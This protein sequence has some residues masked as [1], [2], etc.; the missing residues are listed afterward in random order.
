MLM[1]A[2][3]RSGNAH[4]ADLADRIKAGR[5]MSQSLEGASA[6]LL[7]DNAGSGLA[8]ATDPTGGADLRLA[9]EL[10][11]V[12]L[13]SHIIDPM[14]TTFQGM[15]WELLW[16]ALQSPTW[17]KAVWDRAQA[18]ELQRF[19]VPNAIHLPMAAPNR[20]YDVTPPDPAKCKLVVSFVG[21]QNTTYFSSN[22]SVPSSS[23]LSGVLA[24]AV[25]AD[26]K[27]VTFFDAYHNLFGIGQAVQPDDTVAIVARKS[28]QYFHNK[29]F[30]N[31]YQCL[32]QRD[33]FVIFLARQL[34]DG[35]QLIGNGWKEAY[36]IPSSSPI[37]SF[38]QYLQQFRESAI[39]LN[40]VNGN[41]ETGVNMR[42]FEITAAGGFMLCREQP[43]LG[44]YFVI[45]KECATFSSEVDLLDKIRFY[46]DHPRERADIARAGQLRTLS[47]HLYSHRLGALLQT[48]TIKP[49]PVRF[50]TSTWQDDCRRYIPDA[51]IVLDCGANVGQMARAFRSVFPNAAIFCFEPVSRLHQQLQATCESIK[52]KLVPLAVGD[53]DGSAD[54][55]LTTS[56]EAASLFAYQPGNPCAKWTWV[57]D[58]ESIHVC[59]LDRWSAEEHI[60]VGQI[61]MIKL[62]VQGA[63]LKALYGA[64]N[65]LKHVRVVLLEVAFVPIYKDAPL[66][67]EIDCFMR[68]CGFR[69][70]AVYP[71]DQPN[72][73]GDALYVR[74]SSRDQR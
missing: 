12:P 7:L 54:I 5:L 28:A 33:R 42:A 70:E 58:K 38:D 64:R 40:L 24:H 1:S 16:Q 74:S 27:D 26:L 11:G 65:L 23:L 51:R 68:E 52:A 32:R 20:A 63:E 61:D 62:D 53:F 22:T 17:V 30:Y 15:P 14:V 48:M 47:Q 60:D 56:P 34:G 50:S 49:P 55:N 31:A 21:G 71:S 8:L 39:N 37:D 2:V 46:L 10:A 67:A 25:R 57:V 59:T 35:F 69:Q 6:S 66:Y 45:G 19:G 41:A 73:W 3:H 13:F 44:D 72:N 29:L 9:H 36:G 18:I 43:E 4:F